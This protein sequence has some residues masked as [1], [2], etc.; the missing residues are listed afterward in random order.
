MK[1]EVEVQQIKTLVLNFASLVTASRRGY[2]KYRL[3]K[4]KGIKKEN[5][6]LHLKECDFRYDTKTTQENLYQKLLKLIR[7]NLL[8]LS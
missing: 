8:N 1:K 3:S 5:F 6:L 7:E 2:A 4:F